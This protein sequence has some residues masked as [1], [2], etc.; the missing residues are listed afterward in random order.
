MCACSLDRA[1]LP[2][3][4]LL[5][6]SSFN[7]SCILNLSQCYIDQVYLLLVV[8]YQV[9]VVGAE[10][11]CHS[12]SFLMGADERRGQSG[13]QWVAHEKWQEVP[14]WRGGSTTCLPP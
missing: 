13:Q 2:S 1:E 8:L 6:R 3:E 5:K 4:V 12:L 7:I 9:A 10:E 11:I 14:Y